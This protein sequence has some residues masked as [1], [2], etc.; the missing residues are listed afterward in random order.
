VILTPRSFPSKHLLRLF[1]L[2]N[3]EQWN[4]IRNYHSKSQYHFGS[5]FSFLEFSSKV[6]FSFYQYWLIITANG[7]KQARTTFTAHEIRLQPAAE[8]MVEQGHVQTLNN[9]LVNTST[10]KS[11]NFHF[12]T[13]LKG[14][15]ISNTENPTGSKLPWSL[16]WAWAVRDHHRIRII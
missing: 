2:L 7:Y 6:I 12:I 9:K 11:R 8:T 13:I 16:L 10:R 15:S 4:T 5:L 1:W 3:L 14:N